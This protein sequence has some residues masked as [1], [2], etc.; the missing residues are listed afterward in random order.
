[1]RTVADAMTPAVSVNPAAT[2]QDASTAMLDAGAHAAVVVD[3]GRVCGLVTA[4]DVSRALADGH[5]PSETLVG[6]V[7]QRN[8]PLLRPEEP[9]AEVHERMRAAARDV[10]PVADEHDEPIG[11][12]IDPEARD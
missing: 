12:L 8:P 3:D 6:A 9:L 7:A 4:Q 1:M 10:L 5:D 2:I 11:L